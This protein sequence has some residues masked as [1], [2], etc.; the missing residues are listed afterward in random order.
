MGA[1][2]FYLLLF[3]VIGVGVAGAADFLNL[4]LW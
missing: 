2:M 1:F 3:G 4:F